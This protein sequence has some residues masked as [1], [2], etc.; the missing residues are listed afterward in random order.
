MLPRV[1]SWATSATRKRKAE[2]SRCFHL[3]EAGLCLK[4]AMCTACIGVAFNCLHELGLEPRPGGPMSMRRVLQGLC[5][6]LAVAIADTRQT[7]APAP[8]SPAPSTQI[9]GLPA[10]RALRSPTGIINK[11]LRETV[12]YSANGWAGSAN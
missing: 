11:I 12:I 3:Y 9:K 10:P 5:L 1:R 2:N 7:R 8:P 6:L 4:E